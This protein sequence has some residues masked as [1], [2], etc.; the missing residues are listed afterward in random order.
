M[1]VTA[2]HLRLQMVLMMPLPLEAPPPQT[3]TPDRRRKRLLEDGRQMWVDQ[4][5]SSN[6]ASVT[7][8]FDLLVMFSC[9]SPLLKIGDMCQISLNP[10]KDR[11]VYRPRE[12]RRQPLY[13]TSA[14]RSS[15]FSTERRCFFP[16]FVLPTYAIGF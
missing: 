14:G 7:R 2:Q 15:M 3:V 4:Q 1:G 13:S 10:A 9:F 11:D 16:A 12:V 5:L 6:V 8:A